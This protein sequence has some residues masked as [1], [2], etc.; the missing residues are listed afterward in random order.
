[1]KEA[2]FGLQIGG[3]GVDIV[4]LVMSEKG[5]KGIL[6]SKFTLGGDASVAAGPMG[7]DTEAQTDATMHADILSWSKSR[8]VFGGV[9]L[10]GGTLREDK[11]GN[12]EIYGQPEKSSDILA[13]SVKPTS[14]PSAFLEKLNEVGGSE[15]KK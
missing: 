8:G 15:R 14:A 3:E 1:L 2:G 10:T 12:K 7:R 9:A 4:M 13:G 5:M 6:E 11:D